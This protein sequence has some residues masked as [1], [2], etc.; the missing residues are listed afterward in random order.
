[1]IE[2]PRPVRVSTSEATKFNLP[3]AECKSGVHQERE[4]PNQ[5]RNPISGGE[6]DTLPDDSDLETVVVKKGPWTVEED[7]IL[8][9]YVIKVLHLQ[10]IHK[11]FVSVCDEIKL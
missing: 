3:A 5:S 10:S 6:H 11:C 7:E 4:S 9:N 8:S 2:L 1:M